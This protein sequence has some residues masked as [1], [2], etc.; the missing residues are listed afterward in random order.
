M[1]HTIALVSSKGGTGKTTTALNL[2]VALA[3]RGRR[4]LLVD[5]D[6]QGA[7][8]LCL[9]KDDTEW[10]GLA[11]YLMEEAPIEELLVQT[12]LEDLSLLPRGRLDPVDSCEFE[13]FVGSSAKIAELIYQVSDHFDFVL[14]DAPS[15]LGM[16]PR[17]AMAVSD[18][19]LVPLQAEPLALRSFHQ[20][21]RVLNEVRE[22]QN[23]QLQLLG[24]LPV[25]V[26]LNQQPSLNVMGSLWSGFDCVLDTCIP[27]SNIF[28]GASEQGIPLSFCAGSTPPEARR[29]DALAHEIEGKIA[30]LRGVTGEDDDKQQQQLV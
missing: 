5:L 20:L 23:P 24:V 26:Q 14:F 18:F 8:G 3:Q 21:M 16:I 9:A 13:S 25:M 17:A 30:Q 7:L 4:T 2:G 6:P 22:S 12:K 10:V 28:I 29:F 27:R 19:V 11:E 15:G 1:T